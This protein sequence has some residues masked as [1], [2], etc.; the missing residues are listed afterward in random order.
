MSQMKKIY[1]IMVAVLLMACMLLAGC[2][3][4]PD[5]AGTPTATPTV[6]PEPTV[7]PTAPAEAFVFNE[8]S[9]GENVEVPVDSSI[10]IR[11]DENPTTGYS[12]NVT[13]SQGLEYVNDTF[14]PPETQLIGAGGVHEWEYRAPETG[15]AEFSAIYKRPWEE[16]TGNET[17]FSM[18]F[19]IT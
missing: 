14:I 17:M 18:T 7:T 8:T 13:S 16:T 15:D 5:D 6:T 4:Q 10:V 9:N 3:S 1:G 19:T 2:T 11:L 12:W